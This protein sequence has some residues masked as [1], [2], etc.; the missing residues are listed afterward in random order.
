LIEQCGWKGK[1]VGNVGVHEKQA[2]VIVNYGLATGEEI[3]NFARNII[4]VVFS[5]FGLILT[6]EVNII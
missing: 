3:K 1:R 5:K 6:V 2:L 4:D